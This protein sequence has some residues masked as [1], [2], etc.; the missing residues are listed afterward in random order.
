[1]KDYFDF[2]VPPL[3]GFWWQEGIAGYDQHHKELFEWYALIRMPEFVTPEVLSWAR[4]EASRKKQQDFSKVELLTYEEGL[5]V[6]AVHFGPYDLE[7]ET[8]AKTHQFAETAG[9]V[10]DISNV[11]HHHEIYY[12]D[13]R[14]TA[15]EKLKTLIRHPIRQENSANN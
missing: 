6:Q 10:L 1:M 5:C 12:S 7:M 3:E 14:R 2:V 11:R 13:P 15:P 9:Y 4:Q 8:T